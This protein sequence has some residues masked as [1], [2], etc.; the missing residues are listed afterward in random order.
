MQTSLNFS[1]VSKAYGDFKALDNVSL[2]IE[3]GEFM[4]L[5]GP[6]GSG[7][8]TMLM[9][10]AGFVTP[11]AGGVFLDSANITSLPPEMR[12]FGLVFQGYA[13][14]PHMTVA[15]NVAYPLRIRGVEQQEIDARVHQV[16]KLIQLEHLA[17][18]YPKQLSG[19]Q[20][21]RVAL[22]RSLVF[23]PELLLLDEPLSALDRALRKDLQREL[24]DIHERVGTTFIYVTHDQ[25]EA[26]SMSD[27]IAILRDGR[28][29]QVG[30]PEDLYKKPSTIFVANFLGK[31][32]FLPADLGRVADEKLE[33]SVNGAAFQLR[34]DHSP[35]VQQTF[36]IALRPESLVLC[37]EA[38]K[39]YANKI[40]G[41][42]SKVSYFGQHYEVLVN[43]DLTDDLMVS[44]PI[45]D[46]SPKQG[47]Y[48]HVGWTAGA[49]V[50]LPG[51]TTVADN[52]YAG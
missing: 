10:I 45:G 25:E 31:S 9:V 21:Q 33:Y 37:S 20:Q 6:S 38:D 32:N 50:A 17:E 47:D 35:D 29:E 26:L 18:R 14:F 44:V 3:A 24:K 13:L 36:T 1:S 42:I 23:E 34:V 52:A 4:T 49:G 48:V 8:T 41:L 40:P 2:E 51:R 27:R 46:V 16:L 11:T 19:G 7:K 28:I 15:R 5:L 22:A 30:S 12:N 43:T 39:S